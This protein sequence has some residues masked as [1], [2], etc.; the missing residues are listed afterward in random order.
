MGDAG[1]VAAGVPTTYKDHMLSPKF[2]ADFTN[3]PASVVADARV[4]RNV[5]V[6]LRDATSVGRRAPGGLCGQ[7]LQKYRDGLEL[8]AVDLVDCNGNS[9]DEFVT[10]L[11][12]CFDVESSGTDATE[13]YTEPQVI[14]HKSESSSTDSQISEYYKEE[15]ALRS[16]DSESESSI[17]LESS[18]EVMTSL[19]SGVK[20]VIYESAHSQEASSVNPAESETNKDGGKKNKCIIT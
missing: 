15:D 12:K 13:Q 3:R 7:L 10:R 4:G 14:I 6:P 19:E 11:Q 20:T 8:A 5:N 18:D 1:A 16:T 17:S 2:R 9:E